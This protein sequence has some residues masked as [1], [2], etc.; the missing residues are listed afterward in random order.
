M[1]EWVSCWVVGLLRLGVGLKERRR[2]QGAQGG[3]GAK[4][5]SG[6][7]DQQIRSTSSIVFSV[8]Q[9][10][11]SRIS[12]FPIEWDSYFRTDTSSEKLGYVIYKSLLEEMSHEDSFIKDMV[13][14][15]KK[16]F[17]KY[18]NEYSLIL[19]IALVFEP[20]YKFTFM[21]WAFKNIAI[22]DPLAYDMSLR[23]K[24]ELFK[25]FNAYKTMDVADF[26]TPTPSF[27]YTRPAELEEF[28]A[29]DNA[30]LIDIGSLS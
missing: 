2:W 10:C 24:S 7:V 3:G 12:L 26:K 4:V 15:M 28:M 11:Y 5:P 14:V 23:V 25:L 22:L 17:D 30:R 1:E 19:A 21:D 29:F 9:S 6:S 27:N 18:W 16:K 13:V 8:E 20:R